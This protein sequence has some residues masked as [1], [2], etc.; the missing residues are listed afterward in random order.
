MKMPKYINEIIISTLIGILL[1]GAPGYFL[2]GPNKPTRNEVSQMI[3]KEAPV[4]V[5]DTLKSIEI[6]QA[7]M[8]TDIKNILETIRTKEH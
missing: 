1:G 3:R 7:E 6:Q 2:I 5:Y 8:R 4:T